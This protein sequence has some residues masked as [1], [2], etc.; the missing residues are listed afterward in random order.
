MRI[1]KTKTELSSYLS[2]NSTLSTAFVPTMGALHKGHLELVKKAKSQSH[3]VICSIFVNPTQFDKKEDFNNY[4]N[5]LSNDLMQ[6]KKL[7]CDIVYT[8]TISDLYTKNEKVKHYD[9]DG[10]DRVLE[11]QFRKGH[12]DGVVTIIEKFFSIIKP[13]KAF[14]G[15]K[16]LQQLLIVKAL[17]KKLNLPIEIICIPTV[18]EKSGLAMSSRNK[19]LNEKELEKATILYKSL[20]Y[21]KKKSKNLSIQQLKENISICFEKEESLKLEYLAFA[22]YS[23]LKS[24]SHLKKEGETAVCIAAFVAGVRLIDNIIF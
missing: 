8:P 20:L 17:T 1:F 14:F 18:R 6:L 16:D 11:G 24:I 13:Q 4:P 22:N 19:L 5:T 3:I 12:F 15:Q 7:N 2:L 23:T 21:C 10:L 9:F